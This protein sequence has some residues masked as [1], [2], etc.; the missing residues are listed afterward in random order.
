M[1]RRTLL[2][3]AATAVAAACA[4]GVWREARPRGAAQLGV[5]AVASFPHDRYAYTQG[6]VWHD[7]VLFESTGQ[8][9]LSSVRRVDL[10]SGEVRQR[11]TLP[12]TLFGEG[13][14]VVGDRLVQLTWR[15]GRGR[16]YDLDTLEVVGDFR[17]EGEGW[18]LACDGERLVMSDGTDELRFLD[19]QSFAELRRLPVRADGRPVRQINELEWVDG[20]I[21]ANV[22]RTDWILRIDPDSGEVTAWID[23]RGLFDYRAI[24]DEDAVPNGIAWDPEGRRLFLTGK[25]WP[26][27]FQVELVERED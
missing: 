10:L 17:Y 22:W 19:M 14:T 8:Y 11:V 6:L 9:G 25:L 16:V 15:S 12:R 7:G 13:L 5:R 3:L 23:L 20:Q 21:L 2:T 4:W 27:V 24:P 18:G 1:T 26:K